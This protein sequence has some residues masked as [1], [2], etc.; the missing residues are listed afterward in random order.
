MH[1]PESALKAASPFLVGWAWG[2]LVLFPLVYLTLVFIVGGGGRFV[3][4]PYMMI[5]N[6]SLMFLALWAI[7]RREG[8]TLP[9]IGWRSRGRHHLAVQL[10]LG[11]VAGAALYALDRFAIEPLSERICRALHWSFS[12]IPRARLR[13]SRMRFLA[14]VIAS[15]LFTGVVEESVYRGYAIGILRQRLGA[16]AALIV[17][18]LFFA[19]MHLGFFGAPGMIANGFDGLLLGGLFLWSG[20]ILP[21]AI[22]HAFGNAIGFMF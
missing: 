3:S 9:D 8:W 13:P 11:L 4:P 22:A 12:G 17:T 1:R 6:H 19:V 2:L 7:L 16:P 10:V 18:S 14:L 21:P 15:T 5:L 20:G